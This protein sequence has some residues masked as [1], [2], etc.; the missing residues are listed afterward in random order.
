MAIQSHGL[1]QESTR[2]LPIPAILDGLLDSSTEDLT[3]LGEN[4]SNF[5]SEYCHQGT[6]SD[7]IDD[8][9]FLNTAVSVAISSKGLASCSYE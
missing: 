6:S 8:T 3:S 9:D 7:R 4:N 5:T 2:R 1:R